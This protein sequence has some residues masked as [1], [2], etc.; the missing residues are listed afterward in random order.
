MIP[1]AIN[2]LPND[3]SNTIVLIPQSL[4]TSCL[5]YGTLTILVFDVPLLV[6]YQQNENNKQKVALGVSLCAGH[7][8]K[9]IGV[10]HAGGCGS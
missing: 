1:D 7:F 4:F 10:H 3:L 9:I 8:S 6:F 5:S 2:T